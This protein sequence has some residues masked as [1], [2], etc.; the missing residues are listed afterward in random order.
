MEKVLDVGHI[1]REEAAV[2]ADGVAAQRHRAFV[3]D[4]LFEKCHGL[5]GGIF[6]SDRGLFDLGEQARNRVHLAHEVTHL[7]KGLGRLM[8]H[9]LR[10]F[11]DEV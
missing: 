4:V 9:Q 8:N 5:G 10:A 6:Q 11:G 3:G 1:R 7:G 2:G